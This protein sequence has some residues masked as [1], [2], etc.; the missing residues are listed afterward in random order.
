MFKRNRT[1]LDLRG[2]KRKHHVHFSLYLPTLYTM[3]E[4]NTYTLD[5]QCT[6]RIGFW[7]NCVC[8]FYDYIFL[9][10]YTCVC[11]K[12]VVGLSTRVCTHKSNGK[13]EK[14]KKKRKEGKKD[15]RKEVGEK[16]MRMGWKERKNNINIRLLVYVYQMYGRTRKRVFLCPR[17]PRSLIARRRRPGGKYTRA[18]CKHTGETHEVRPPSAKGVSRV[19]V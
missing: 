4:Y 12:T 17:V 14:T 8:A 5:L 2:G 16:R 18:A 11:I 19:F 9:N 3:Y 13:V 1:L 7:R 10:T 15:P 6:M